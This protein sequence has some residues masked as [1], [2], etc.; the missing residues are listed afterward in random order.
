MG[1][2]GYKMKFITIVLMSA[3]LTLAGAKPI[4]AEDAGHGHEY[5]TNTLFGFIGITGEDRRE[6]AGTLAIEYERRFNE[7]WGLATGIEHAFG[8]LNFTVFTVPV[9]F[10]SDNWGLYAGPGVEKQEHHGS[11]FLF[12][13]GAVYEIEAGSVILAPKINVDFVGGDVVLVGGL[14]IGIGF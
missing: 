5:H 11:K 12:R 8:D 6:R 13:I 9:V 14:A 2:K 4:F 10:H 1:R 7:R 3:F